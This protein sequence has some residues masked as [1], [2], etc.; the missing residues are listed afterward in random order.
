MSTVFS[1]ADI[2]AAV[3]AAGCGSNASPEGPHILKLIGIITALRS[4]VKQ[5]KDAY[6]NSDGL[7][8]SLRHRLRGGYAYEDP[9]PC[10]TPCGVGFCENQGC[11]FEPDASDHAA[12]GMAREASPGVHLPPASSASIRQKI[13]LLAKV[14]YG[15]E[16]QWRDGLIGVLAEIAAAIEAAEGAR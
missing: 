2:D 3:K 16:A 9:R 14:P 7:V 11:R 8:K 1:D 4:E 6:H 5:Y 13:S 10:K 12:E 15:W